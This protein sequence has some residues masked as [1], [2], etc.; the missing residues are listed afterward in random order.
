[1][2]T[3]RRVHILVRSDG[4]AS[5]MSRYLIR[6]IEDSRVIELHTRT[7]IVGLEGDTDLRRVR[8]RDARTGTV[9]T[10][11]I[12]HVFLMTGAIP[13]TAWLGGCIALDD[14]GFVKTG[15][16]LTTDDLGT[17]RWPLRRPPLQLETSRSGVFAVGD[18]RSGSM[19]R[20]A[21]AVGEGAAAISLVHQVL[22][23]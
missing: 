21:A 15:G 20:V 13:N 2:A 11:D 8:W 9:E 19:K 6:R 16:A 22:A 23:E 14:N 12:R 17:S 4:L 1:S 18:V 3:S 7:E 5:T 10:H